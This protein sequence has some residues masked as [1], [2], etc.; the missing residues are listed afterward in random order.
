MICESIVCESIVR[1]SSGKRAFRNIVEEFRQNS[2]Y[3]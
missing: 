2:L 3:F 1:E